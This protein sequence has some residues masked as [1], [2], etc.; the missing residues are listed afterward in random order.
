MNSRDIDKAID[1]LKEVDEL[2]WENVKKAG[3]LF[4]DSIM[5]G[6][7]I[8]AF[9]SGHSEVGARE[10]VNRAGGLFSAKKIKDPSE[11]LFE[12]LEG[13]GY[14]LTD[15]VEILPED[16][17]VVISNS[18]RNPA[19]IEI[20]M[21]AKEK[22]AKVVAVTAVEASKHTTSR[23]S[24]GKK[25]YELADVVLDLHTEDG[26]AAIQVD[27]LKE[28]ICGTSTIVTVGLLQSVVMYSVEYMISKGFNPPVRVSANLDGG[29]NRSLEI[30]K[31]YANRI[32][33]F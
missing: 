9:G 21:R 2:E 5:K 4:G 23:H 11:G 26:D 13:S 18:G 7:I 6:G 15:K 22:G 10:L 3:E 8:I 16:V 28:R 31:Q 12:R 25:L 24:S 27:G 32:Y 17:V 30:E 19:G 33:R 1:F 29:F 20:A 14:L